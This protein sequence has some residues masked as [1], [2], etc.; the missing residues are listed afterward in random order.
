[1]KK[2]LFV[3]YGLEN[4]GGSERV[5]TLL[6]NNLVDNYE[7]DIIC[8]K[9]DRFA[10]QLDERINTVNLDKSGINLILG[11][12]KQIE[13]NSYD[14][15]VIHSMTKLTVSLLL[16]GLKH[17]NLITVEHI[18]SESS[19]FILKTLKRLLYPKVNNIVVL[20]KKDAE[21][22]NKLH[23]SVSVIRNPSPFAS[24]P[25][26][27][28]QSRKIIAIGSLIKRKGFDRLIEAW[29]DI[30]PLSKDFT[31]DIYG[32]GEEKENLLRLIEEYKLKKIRLMGQTDNVYEIYK[33]ASFFIMTSH[34]EGLPMV[35]IEAQSLGLPI[36]S[37]DCPYGPSEI[38][39]DGANGYLVEDNNKYLLVE[40]VLSLINNTQLRKSMSYNALA[41]SKY[42]S[43]E[44]VKKRWL[45]LF[46]M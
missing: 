25:L 12:K 32:E 23:D 30:E 20:T 14:F 37:Y 42:Y 33:S 18:S 13:N 43:I 16:A 29:K 15:V 4:R 44:E 28:S 45:D 10:Y 3:I 17:H 19:G 22:Y 35:L 5:A 46:G 36:V 24:K 9:G 11:F 2:V 7:V 40:K 21:F 6:A 8:R 34:F 1:M 31:L 38:I 27:S 39:T 26:Y 41:N